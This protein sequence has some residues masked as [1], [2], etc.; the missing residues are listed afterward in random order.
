MKKLTTNGLGDGDGGLR[1]VQRLLKA[2]RRG[3]RGSR[4]VEGLLAAPHAREV[5]EPLQLHGG[6]LGVL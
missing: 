1:E 6:D 3:G 4:V 2:D 5:A